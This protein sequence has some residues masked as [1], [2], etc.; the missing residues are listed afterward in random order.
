MR[1]LSRIKLRS[2][3]GLALPL[4]I[5]VMAST[6]AIGRLGRQ[7]LDLERAHRE[8][9]EEPRQRPDARG[10]RDRERPRGP[11]QPGRPRSE[12]GDAAPRAVHTL[13]GSYTP[14]SPPWR[15]GRR[16]TGAAT[17]RPTYKWTLH[18]IGSAAEPD[19]RPA[20]DDASSPATAQ[21]RGLND[22]SSVGAWNRMY[23]NSTTTCLRIEDVTIP[24]PIASRGDICLV[25]SAK[26]TG[27][28]TTVEVGD[29]VDHDERDRGGLDEAP[30]R[31]IGLDELGQRR[32]QQQPTMR[33]P[34]SG[35][36]ATGRW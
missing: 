4:T 36:P 33:A 29:D 17:S 35:S 10:S 5:L 11:E 1:F 8:R 3:R 32:Q 19:R 31:R 30:G 7:V 12:G 23:H 22:G 16:R 24:T 9:R 2:E 6:G 28:A 27:A 15:A 21:V 25:G 14:R 26:I 34:R 20:A 18:S 13:A